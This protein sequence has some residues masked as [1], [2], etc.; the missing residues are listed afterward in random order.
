MSPDEADEA[1]VDPARLVLTPDPASRSGKGVR[2]IGWAESTGRLITVITMATE[3]GHLYG[4][5][6]SVSSAR[7]ARWYQEKETP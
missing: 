6:A 4:V 5:N 2:T 7:N 3:D 1:L